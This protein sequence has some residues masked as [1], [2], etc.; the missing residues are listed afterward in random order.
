MPGTDSKKDS[1][2]D[3]SLDTPRDVDRDRDSG[4]ERDRNAKAK[5]PAKS[6]SAIA[7]RVSMAHPTVRDPDHLPAKDLSHVPCKFF[8]V[9]SCTAGSSCPFSHSILEPGQQKEVCAW[10]VKGNCKFGHKCALAHILPGQPMSMDRKNKKAAQLA[11]NSQ[12]GPGGGKEGHKAGRSQKHASQGS[13]GG[14]SQSR[15]PLF[16]GSTA[17]TRATSNASRSSMPMPLKTTLSPSTPAPP[18]KDTDFASFGLPDENNKLPSAP[19]HGKP[20]SSSEAA[21]AAEAAQAELSISGE[22]QEESSSLPMSTPTAPRNPVVLQHSPPAIDLGPIGSPPRS[23][24]AGGI[25]T[26]LNGLSP[27]TSPVRHGLST[28]PFSAPGSQSVFALQEDDGSHDFR[29]RSG[30]SASLGASMSWSS[31]RM[32]M[33][34]RA[35][36]GSHIE[37]VT[38]D[39]VEDEDLEEFLPSSLT[40]LL[41]PEERSRRM[42]RANAARPEISGA[43]R[44]AA[45]GQRPAGEGHH[46]YSRSVPAPSLLKDIRSIW[47]DQN[48]AVSGSSDAAGSFGAGGLGNGTPSSFTSNSGL[49]G[50]AVGEDMLAP[51]NASAAFLPSIHHHFLG[52]K[53]RSSLLNGLSSMYPP[54]SATAMNQNGFPSTYGTNLHGAAFS[55]PRATPFASRTPFE[56][57]ASDAHTLRFSNGR[58]IPTGMDGFGPDADDVRSAVSPSVRALQ[59]HAP[60]Q[61]LPQGLA[62]GYSRIHALP[63]PVIPSPSTSGTFNIGSASAFAPGTPGTKVMGHSHSTSSDWHGLPSGSL[64]PSEQP[65]VSQGIAAEGTTQQ[66]GGHGGLEAMFSRLSYSA[67]TMRGNTAPSGMGSRIPSGRSYQGPGSPLSGPVLTNDDDLFSMD[68]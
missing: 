46:R 62:A 41:T 67:A 60:G 42:S 32:T 44:E 59:A 7:S 64:P 63:P 10:F 23:S 19:A 20:H 21:T 26:R 65:Q 24:P 48:N 45:A 2:S 58:P 38:E 3:D 6:A 1:Q 40:D 22:E 51:S 9:G 4:R 36:H 29:N 55:P 57:A 47:S 15:N 5:G 12:G 11:A 52:A 61:S 31:S 25:P 49:A 18:V 68:G 53:Q 28:S 37:G 33:Q 13:G 17:P 8:K 14:S 16:S 56:S 35:F 50:R 30:I 54:K 66:G 27:G 43:D 34:R 39:V